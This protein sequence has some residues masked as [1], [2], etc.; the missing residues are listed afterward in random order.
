V[1]GLAQQNHK[2]HFNSSFAVKVFCFWGAGI[3]A[4]IF[5]IQ[6]QIYAP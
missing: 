5:L 1:Y 2:Q 3:E 4:Q 6:F